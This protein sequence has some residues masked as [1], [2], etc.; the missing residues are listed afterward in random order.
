MLVA[1][2]LV[3]RINKLSLSCKQ[4]TRSDETATFVPYYDSIIDKKHKKNL[5]EVKTNPL[6][7]SKVR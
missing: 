7:L 1:E 5:S 2:E 3:K 6:V 4:N